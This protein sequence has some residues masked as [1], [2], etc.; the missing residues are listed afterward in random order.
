MTIFEAYNDCKKQL[1]SAGIE[2]YVFESKQ[3]IKHITGYNNAQILTNYTQPLN[4]FQQNNLT[5]II[6]QRLIHYPLQYIIGRWNFFGY[7]FFVGPGV[8]I[9]RAD[10]ET[11]M[12][13]CLETLKEKTDPR[14]LDLCAG[15][16]CIGITIKGEIPTADVTLVEKYDE[17][18]SYLQKNAEHNKADVN[19]IKGD[20]LKTEGADGLYDLIVSNPPYIDQKDM[21][22]LQIEVTFEP[23][24][25][26]AGGQDGLDFYRHIAK[27]YKRYLKNGGVMAFEVGI[28]Q[29]EAVAE[30][31]K[32]NGFEN[33]GTRED[34][35]GIRRAVFGTANNI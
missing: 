4:E 3:I 29:D 17:A 5:V 18:I 12:D 10:T 28:N 25:A 32:Q 14:V 35:N 16:G 9:P 20:V 6:K 34:M 22:E 27:E 19:L 7:E 21:S 26:L 33:I 13:V 23:S 24:T 11:L 15:T 30:I 31:L 1:Q 8:L 2:D